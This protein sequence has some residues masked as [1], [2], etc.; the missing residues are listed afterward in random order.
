[1]EVQDYR[2]ALAPRAPKPDKA[3]AP[4]PDLQS[5]IASPDQA[6]SMPLVSISINQTVPVRDALFELAKQVNYD[7]EIDPRITGSIIYTAHDRPLDEVVERIS[8]LAGLRYHFDGNMMHVQL[9]TPYLKTYKID[10]LSYVRKSA[11]SI[12]N[13]VSLASSGGQTG[14]TGAAGSQF[15]AQSEGEA[16]FFGELQTNLTQILGVPSDAGLMRT[17]SDPQIIRCARRGARRVGRRFP[18]R[19]PGSRRRKRR[20]RSPRCRRAANAAC[21]S[22]PRPVTSPSTSRPASFR[23]TPMTGSRNRW[24]TTSSCCAGRSPRRC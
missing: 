22:P 4:I 14:G 5:Y 16:N 2:D 3:S 10:Y 17:D 19:A 9:D 1:M 6:K 20:C 24:A 8:V 12:Q 11:S 18:A 23:F 13:S 15:Q 21:R 7:A